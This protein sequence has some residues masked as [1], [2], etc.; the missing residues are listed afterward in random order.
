[1]NLTATI[2]V[3][4]DA[5]LKFVTDFVKLRFDYLLKRGVEI[6]ETGG[7]DSLHRYTTRFQESTD[8]GL[9][10]LLIF[11]ANGSFDTRK[12]DLS[13]KTVDLKISFESFL[14]P[15]DSDSGDLEVLLE[16]IVNPDYKQILPCFVKFQDCLK[17]L[18]KPQ[19]KVPDRKAKVFLYA[20]VLSSNEEAKEVNRN[21][22][23]LALWNLESD[24]LKP[25][26][27]FLSPYFV[28][29]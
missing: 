7:K 14:F 2:F 29:E 22:M 27:D 10:N 6:Q 25:L 23:N 20:S 13:K 3:E 24:Y 17:S 9:T 12:T 1:M 4:G 26:F 11:D 19:I 5:D 16:N 15:N 28:K 8:L 18:D 21:Y